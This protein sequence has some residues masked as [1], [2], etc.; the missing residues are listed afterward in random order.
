MMVFVAVIATYE[1]QVAVGVTERKAVS[2]VSQLA[3]LYLLRRQAVR[4]ETSTPRKVAD[5]FGGR[6]YEVE[7]TE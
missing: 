5:Y 2:A 1:E 7:V 4:P 3:Y 6:V